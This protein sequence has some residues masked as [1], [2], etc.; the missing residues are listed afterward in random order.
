MILEIRVPRDNEY[1]PESAIA[2]FAGFTKTLTRPT[3]LKKILKKPIT[4]T[5]LSLEVACYG[6]QIHFF[7]IFEN[8]LVSFFESQLLAAYPLAIM[9]K[10]K[11]AGREKLNK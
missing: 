2:L 4:G 10:V 9:D 7:A 1:T 3:L 11:Q 6:Q 8:E 5:H